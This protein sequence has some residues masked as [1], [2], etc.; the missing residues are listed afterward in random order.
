MCQC[1]N[2]EAFVWFWPS[3]NYCVSFKKRKRRKKQQQLLD[4]SCQVQAGWPISDIAT[5][6]WYGTSYHLTTSWLEAAT[7]S[8]CLSRLVNLLLLPLVACWTCQGRL[9]QHTTHNYNFMHSKNTRGSFEFTVFPDSSENLSLSEIWVP[10]NEVYRSISKTRGVP[11][12]SPTMP[13]G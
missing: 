1:Q 6:I 4:G 7:R 3:Y 2:K 12:P 11:H 8:A 10:K 5:V 13:V 9:E